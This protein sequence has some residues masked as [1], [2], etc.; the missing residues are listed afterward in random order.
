MKKYI[1]FI[2]IM[3]FLSTLF[4]QLTFKSYAYQDCAN[5]IDK[6]NDLNSKDLMKYIEK[7]YDNADVNY[8]CTY[9]TCYELKNINIKNGLVR[10]I[11]LLKERGLDEQA[12]EAEIKGFSATEI[13]LNLCK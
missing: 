5:Y 12:L 1:I 4:L 3:G 8:F 11:D 7:N 6:P 9:Y 10:Y 2:T 13:G